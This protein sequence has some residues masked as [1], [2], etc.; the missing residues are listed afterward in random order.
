DQTVGLATE[1]DLPQSE[2]VIVMVLPGVGSSLAWTSSWLPSSPIHAVPGTGPVALICGAIL[3]TASALTVPVMRT[4]S[5][6]LTVSRPSALGSEK[7]ASTLARPA[8]GF[9]R[10]DTS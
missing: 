10:T 5:T 1:T 8:S 9:S 7:L 4:A 6:P 2:Q 3:L